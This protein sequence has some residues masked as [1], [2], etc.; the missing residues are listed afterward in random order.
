VTADVRAALER[1]RETGDSVSVNVELP[2][3]RCI[4][5]V[6]VV[7]AV[8]D[9]CLLLT[10]STGAVRR[11]PVSRI[12][13]VRAVPARHAGRGHYRPAPEDGGSSEDGDETAPVKTGDVPDPDH[14]W[15][16]RPSTRVEE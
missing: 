14:F 3:G 10:D 7:R 9:R 11:M 5:V 8:D 6:G 15:G 12:G 1:A 13:H 4:Q 16:Q 2:A